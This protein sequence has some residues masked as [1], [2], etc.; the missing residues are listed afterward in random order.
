MLTKSLKLE[1]LLLAIGVVLLTLLSIL[2]LTTLLY[3]PYAVLAG[4]YFFPG[5]LL[6]AK[7]KIETEKLISMFVLCNTLF[8]SC[9]MSFVKDN[10]ILTL[11][12]VIYLLINLFFVFYFN[13]KSNKRF[14]L[15]LIAHLI[16]VWVGLWL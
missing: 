2:N 8:I 1:I 4:L 11:V 6:F 5:V 12:G 7:E 16:L 3:I 10:N 15:H 9:L 14:I 13:S